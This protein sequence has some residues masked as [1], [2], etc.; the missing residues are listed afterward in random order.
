MSACSFFLLAKIV[1][2]LIG[3]KSPLILYEMNF[4]LQLDVF[5]YVTLISTKQNLADLLPVQPE[6]RNTYEQNNKTS[7]VPRLGSLVS[8]LELS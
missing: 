1:L 4:T 7:V 6:H 3:F 2:R 5:I 8:D